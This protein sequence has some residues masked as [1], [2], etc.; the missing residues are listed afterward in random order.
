[1]LP[2]SVQVCRHTFLMDGYHVGCYFKKVEEMLAC[3]TFC[4]KLVL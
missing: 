4:G 1:M 3:A 2:F